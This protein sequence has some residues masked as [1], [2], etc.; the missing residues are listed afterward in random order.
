MMKSLVMLGF[1]LKMESGSQHLFLTAIIR[2]SWGRKHA[3]KFVFHL[4]DI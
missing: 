2:V 1:V 4:M 3:L